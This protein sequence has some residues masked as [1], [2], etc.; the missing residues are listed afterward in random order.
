MKVHV[1]AVHGS[2][3]VL[4]VEGD[5]STE[6]FGALLVPTRE[7]RSQDGKLVKEIA[8]AEP[9]SLPWRT[10][11]LAACRD[12]DGGFW[13]DRLADA[14]A[15]VC[16]SGSAYV[17]LPVLGKSVGTAEAQLEAVEAVLGNAQASR[18]LSVLALWTNSAK[19]A[20]AVAELVRERVRSGV[21]VTQRLYST[22]AQLWLGFRDRGANPHHV[23]S[24]HPQGDPQTR[25]EHWLMEGVETTWGGERALFRLTPGGGVAPAKPTEEDPAALDHSAQWD[26]EQLYHETGD[27]QV[28]LRRLGVPG[29][30]LE[31]WI[32]PTD[33]LERARAFDI[34]WRYCAAHPPERGLFLRS[35]LG[36]AAELSYEVTG[37][38]LSDRDQARQPRFGVAEGWGELRSPD[39]LCHA[40]PRLTDIDPEADSTV[41]ALLWADHGAGH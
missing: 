38:G 18:L 1:R 41:V 36:G 20:E 3:C 6:G 11:R 16:L 32:V 15:D 17:S 26:L 2:R 27:V 23:A 40:V 19:R 25:L 29:A 8:A 33:R 13:T 9:R 34:L 4:V 31:R 30:E 24:L 5:L 28:V 14:I 21:W 7:D 22:I 35:L 39:A 12:T 10:I 37:P